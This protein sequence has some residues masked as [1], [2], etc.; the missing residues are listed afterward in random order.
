[1]LSPT[2]PPFGP[3]PYNARIFVYL[4]DG[5]GGFEDPI[6]TSI[7]H[8]FPESLINNTVLFAVTMECF[9]KDDGTPVLLVGAPISP[10]WGSFFILFLDPNNAGHVV[11]WVEHGGFASDVGGLLT[12]GLSINFG[13][14]LQVLG[15]WDE[16]GMP[17]VLVSDASAQNTDLACF[18]LSL[19]P[20]GT[21]KNASA[22]QLGTVPELLWPGA[23][24]ALTVLGDVDGDGVDDLGIAAAGYDTLRGGFHV[25]FMSKENDGSFHSSSTFR[26]DSVPGFTLAPFSRFGGSMK[27]LGDLDGDEIPDVWVTAIGAGNVAGEVYVMFLDREGGVKY[28]LGIGKNESGF[29]PLPER[30]HFGISAT[31]LDLDGDGVRELIVADFPQVPIQPSNLYAF[32]FRMPPSA[33]IYATNTSSSFSR[34]TSK[35]QE[36]LLS[37]VVSASEA[38]STYFLPIQVR[39]TAKAGQDFL[40]PSL[41]AEVT[42]SPSQ[43]QTVWVPMAVQNTQEQVVDVGLEALDNTFREAEVFLEIKLEA[44][45]D[46]F[47]IPGGVTTANFNFA[48]DGECFVNDSSNSSSST[49]GTDTATAKESDREDP[50]AIAVGVTVP[51]VVIL[52][53][54]AGLLAFFVWKR[55]TGARKTIK[56]DLELGLDSQQGHYGTRPAEILALRKN[57]PK[58]HGKARKSTKQSRW[59]ID[60]DEL[61]FTEKI[62]EGA[63]GLVWK[64]KWRT[65]DVAIKCLKLESEDELLEFS[66]ETKVMKHLRPH[67]NV[68]N[69]LGVCMDPP[70]IVMRYL[71]NGSL[72]SYL[73]SNTESITDEMIIS[74]AKDTA[75]GM[76]HLHK[77]GFIHRDL[78]TRNLL[79]DDA[80]H[81]KVADFGMSKA[82][83]ESKDVTTT[84]VG[85]IKWMA[86]ESL[87]SKV[88]SSK[89]DVWAFGVTL[90]EM[91]TRGEEPFPELSMMQTVLVV[92]QEERHLTPPEGSPPILAEIMQDCFQ[93]DPEKRPEFEDILRRFESSS[94]ASE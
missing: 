66:K 54:L 15:D 2:R 18:V 9:M 76:F 88:F 73:R 8:G 3:E 37:V 67:R 72:T 39:G 70:C 4:G 23:G 31:S 22:L 56:K 36:G 57:I 58:S 10:P 90:W 85:P 34:Q 25:L 86:P 49:D 35:R 59:Q 91:I 68:V 64:G 60:F 92:C 40:W 45:L 7:D 42:L 52:L 20:D 75:A 65:M 29:G 84:E 62:G 46:M 28:W 32:T 89:S 94:D 78:A 33:A 50:T 12:P 48:C 83:E 6:D 87:S 19:H 69:L 61:E 79:L 77:E 14:G 5:N 1:M 80:L 38:Q 16:D 53:I 51:V 55:N 21:L 11:S 63:F 26:S 43:F 82:L 41:T 71:P 74:W 93:R 13:H 44:S 27:T 24:T 47:L 17:E 81:V 30:A